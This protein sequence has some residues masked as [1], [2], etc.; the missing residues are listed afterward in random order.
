MTRIIAIAIAYLLAVPA[1]A[2]PITSEV[3]Q[4]SI[5]KNMQYKSSYCGIKVKTV[6]KGG[7]TVRVI[8]ASMYIGTSYTA[9]EHNPGCF[10]ASEFMGI[11]TSRPSSCNTLCVPD[12]PQDADTLDVFFTLSEQGG[13]EII[14]CRDSCDSD[15]WSAIEKTGFACAKF[16][17]W[18]DSRV[19]YAK[20]TVLRR[21]K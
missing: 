10:L 11:P 17:N 18:S 16:K 19:R 6:D 9:R 20:I 12:V 4:C 2:E 1:N 7:M 14:T 3:V 5:A 8:E 15:N 21:V 13:K